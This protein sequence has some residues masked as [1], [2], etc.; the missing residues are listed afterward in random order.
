MKT[1]H[2][3]LKG[4]FKVKLIELTP[5]GKGM[6]LQRT[7][8]FNP[9]GW[10]SPTNLG[11]ELVK[12]VLIQHDFSVLTDKNRIPY[13][14]YGAEKEYLYYNIREADTLA[15]IV[16]YAKETLG[17][18]MCYL[19]YHLLDSVNHR[20]AA[21]YEGLTKT[22]SEEV[23]QAKEIMESSYK[24]VDDFVGELVRN[25]VNENTIVVLVSDHGAVPT[26]KTVNI[27]L[28]FM[29]EG[30]LAYKWN[31]NLKK[32]IVDWNETLAFPYYEPP[33]V[34]INLKGRDPHGKVSSQEYD[35][36]RERVIDCLYNIEE[37]GKRVVA[38]ALKKED[39]AA[40][41]HGGER[42]GDILYL[43]KPSYEIWDDRIEILNAA[44]MLPEI[45]NEG[46][47]RDSRQTFGAHV[48]YLPNTRIGSFSVNSTLI[49]SGP[50][51]NSGLELKK[52]VNLTDVVPTLA[53]IMGIP[54]PKD[55]EGRVLTEL[56]S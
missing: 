20:Y 54:P 35:S 45:M 41:H 5:D 40:L 31:K 51:I 50:G 32:H 9:V 30:L 2:G 46:L 6:V 56:L 22:S 29:E 28:A 14:I 33:Y 47:I 36:L 16:K 34:W 4:I 43:L 53:K 55:S 7:S 3:L 10:T 21:I 11:E 44:E 27:A 49:M 37:N 39:A 42:A 25:C 12:N 23:K 19:H 13:D 38:L 8:V 24:V 17:W 15:K 48:Y 1:I 52:P 26:W 18:N